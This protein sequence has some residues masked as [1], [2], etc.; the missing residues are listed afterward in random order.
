MAPTQHLDTVCYEPGSR[1]KRCRVAGNTL[2]PSSS[3]RHHSAQLL[4]KVNNDMA[5][6]QTKQY[7]FYKLIPPRTTF[8]SDMSA[9]ERDLMEQHVRYWTKLTEQGLAIVFGPVADPRGTW[10]MA[11]VEAVDASAV[12]GLGQED[13]PVKAGLSTFEIYPMRLGAIRE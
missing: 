1:R 4:L 8:A 2:G 9:A 5:M 7:F 13:P 12:E 6:T 11:I 3:T 10:G